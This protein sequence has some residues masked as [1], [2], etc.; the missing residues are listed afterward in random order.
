MCVHIVAYLVHFTV[1]DYSL[2]TFCIAHKGGVRGVAIDGLTME[3]Y[4]GA[5]DRTIKVSY[6]ISL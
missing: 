2:P 5:A 4:S 6:Y 3:V 1:C